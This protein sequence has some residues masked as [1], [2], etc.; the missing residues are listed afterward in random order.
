MILEGDYHDAWPVQ[1]DLL[2]LM[3]EMGR[4]D[5]SNWWKMLRNACRGL[6]GGGEPRRAAELLEQSVA[7]AR[8]ADP[9]FEPPYMVVGCRA[10][11]QVMAGDARAADADLMRAT[12]AAAAA[13]ALAASK[14]YPAMTVLAAIERGDLDAADERWTALQPYEERA[15]AAGERDAEVVRV[16]LTHVRLDLAHGRHTDASKLLEIASRLIAARH[17]PINP[18]AFA[19]AILEAQDAL[20]AGAFAEA[21]QRSAKAVQLGETASVDPGASALIGEALLLR[22]RAESGLGNRA[23]AVAT[24]RA[25]LRHLRSTLLPDSALIGAAQSLIGTALRGN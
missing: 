23:Q 8:R 13:G 16:L 10:A 17:Q 25:S 18:D 9:S 7:E 15:L 20:Q 2:T 1:H 5:T 22:A 3:R 4:D 19:A 12:R 24:A 6:I 14:F 21:A 11:A